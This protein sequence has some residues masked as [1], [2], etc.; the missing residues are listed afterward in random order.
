MI[1]GDKYRVVESPYKYRGVWPGFI[2]A[3]DHYCGRVVTIRT[4][5]FS[6]SGKLYVKIAE[7]GGRFWWSTEFLIP[8][9]QRSE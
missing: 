9:K 8:L 2:S 6:S 7:D 1:V 3:M 4:I 5:D